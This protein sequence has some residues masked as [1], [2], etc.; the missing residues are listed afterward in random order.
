MGSEQS[1]IYQFGDFTLHLSEYTLIKNGKNI[2]LRPKVFEILLLLV[3]SSNSLVSKQ[4]LLEK[5]WPDVIV[6]ENTLT[7]CIDELRKALGDS[8]R[9]PKFIKTIPKLGY[10]FIGDAKLVSGKITPKNEIKDFND[11]VSIQNR[12]NTKALSK[13]YFRFVFVIIILITLIGIF[14]LND[15]SKD[16]L[17]VSKNITLAV[18]PLKNQ[19]I[20]NEEIYFT[21]GITEELISTFSKIN[22]IRVIGHA[23]SMKFKLSPERTAKIISELNITHV[24]EGDVKKEGSVY[25]ISIKLIDVLNQNTIFSKE[26]EKELNYLYAVKSDIVRDVTRVLK[27][28]SADKEKQEIIIPPTTNVEAYIMYLKGRHEWNK[29]TESGFKKAFEYL[30]KAIDLDPDYS[31]AYT[32]LADAYSYFAIYHIIPV[33]E[34]F[35]LAKK[36]AERALVLDEF[37]AEAHISM[38]VVQEVYFLNWTEARKEYK[39]AIE[40][41]PGNANAHKEYSEFLMFMGEF[42]DAVTEAKLAL[43]LD[44]FSIVINGNLGHIYYRTRQFEKAAEQLS[45]TIEM[46]PD[47]LLTVPLWHLGLVYVQMGMPQKAIAE[48]EKW[49]LIQPENSDI[50]GILGYAYA[51]SNNKDEA[52]N[53]LKI[54]ERQLV[55]PESFYHF[56]IPVSLA[57]IYIGLGDTNQAF[58]YLERAYNER[59]SAMIMLK[60]EPF[61]DPLRKDPRFEQLLSRMEFPK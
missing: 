61:F 6:T 48:L 33:K 50:L 13:N 36:A 10:K 52:L 55:E 41:N 23:T 60:T 34:A 16:K 8:A 42:N 12:N 25:H 5:I 3:Q 9:N 27:I 19:L 46:S 2:R 20:N 30:N 15:A 56:D 1:E 44:P 51:V 37:Q 11:K 35:P 29:R 49:T 21:D 22:G 14:V 17:A 7:H 40:L 18:L 47:A 54:L 57:L 28:G 24:I 59:S 58:H 45:N 4:I 53:C 26:Y 43:E 38:G 39:R 32:G 31:L